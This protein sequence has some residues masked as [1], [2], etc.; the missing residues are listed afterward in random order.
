[1]PHRT[2]S[3]FW[4]CS[5]SW[6]LC[7]LQT[8]SRFI[9][10]SKNFFDSRD[11]LSVLVS[12]WAS[13]YPATITNLDISAELASQVCFTVLWV[14]LCDW[15]PFS[16]Q[17]SETLEAQTPPTLKPI[18][19]TAKQRLTVGGVWMKAE[20]LP[21]G[22]S[23]TA[24]KKTLDFKAQLK[25]TI[26][27]ASTMQIRESRGFTFHIWRLYLHLHSC[28]YSYVCRACLRYHT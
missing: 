10:L 25:L 27:T 1:M 28:L 16:V 7:C 19:E 24:R 26:F 22:S 14:Y 15:S 9:S 20:S 23:T 4:G 18:G 8:P 21:G 12:R 13:G 5:F 6:L 3:H 2:L 17:S 11:A